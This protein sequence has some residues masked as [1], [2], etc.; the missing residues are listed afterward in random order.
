M[1]A[2]SALMAALAIV[3][4]PWRMRRFE[5]LD[6][7]A[8]ALRKSDNNAVRNETTGGVSGYARSGCRI[9]IEQVL[10]AAIARIRGGSTV[11]QAFEEQSDQPFATR[12][13]TAARLMT[14]L[15]CR[16]LPCEQHTHAKQVAAGLA[17]AVAVSEELGCRAVPCMEAVLEA[18]RQLRLMRDL[19]AQAFAVPKATV[20]LLSALPVITVALGELMGARPVSFLFGS[21]RGLICLMLGMC[22]YVAG[23]AWMRA[24]M[25]ERR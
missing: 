23:L 12:T 2:I 7:A 25:A 16:R 22:C 3:I 14:L 24:L 1:A 8:G 10:A 11:T 13:L 5:R 17:C 4:W 20:G 18:Y 9:G 15:E 21:Q 19:Q 6:C